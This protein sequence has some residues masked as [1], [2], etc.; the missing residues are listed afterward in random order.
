MLEKLPSREAQES[1]AYD[2]L[3]RFG[4]CQRNENVENFAESL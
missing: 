3:F 1:D 4:L 2:A